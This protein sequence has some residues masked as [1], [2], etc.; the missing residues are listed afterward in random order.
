MNEVFSNCSKEYEIYPLTVI[1]IVDTHKADTK[2]KEF[3]K[4]NATLDKG[5]E[6]QVYTH[7][8]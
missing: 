3:F 1:E 2:L 6:G 4:H 8:L 7:T 5:L